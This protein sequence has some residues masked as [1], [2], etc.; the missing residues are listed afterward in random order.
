M[1]PMITLQEVS[2]TYQLNQSQFYALQPLNLTIYRGEIFGIFGESGAGKSTLL[3]LI[4]LLEKPNSGQIVVEGVDL[5]T[6]NIRELNRKRQQIGMIFQ[7]FNLLASRTAFE[8]IALPLELI[9][10][11]KSEIKARVHTL[12]DLVSLKSHQAHYPAQLS[13]GQKQRVAIARALATEPRILLCDEATSALDPNSTKSILQLLRKI[14]RELNVTIVLITHEMEVIKQICD[15]AAV[16][17]QGRLIECDSTLNIFARPK[18]SITK[19]LV[20]QALHIEVPNYIKENLQQQNGN[21]ALVRLTFI[22]NDCTDSFITSLVR[23]YQLN[24]SILQANIEHIKDTAVGWMV[25]QLEGERAV[26]H[27]AI[28]Y[29]N[30]SSVTAEIIK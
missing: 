7:H 10:K 19:Q 18:A 27:E 30:Q 11:S 8:N 28:A 4:N 1:I 21:V 16:L 12:L 6:L 20:Q 25:C 14:N 17:D 22:G 26:I 23:K 3:R 29:I 5:T 13:G 2:K 9:G 24:I 15:R